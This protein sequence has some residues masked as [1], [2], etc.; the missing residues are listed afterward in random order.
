MDKY[1]PLRDAGTS[2][3]NF[4]LD[5]DAVIEHLRAWDARYGISLSDAGTDSVTVS[6]NEVPEDTGELAADIYAFCPDTVDQHFG[7]IGEMIDMCEETG[8]EVP[9]NVTEL[10]DGVTLEGDYGVELLER[11]LKKHKQVA[12]WWD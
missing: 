2:A 4:D 7:C 1:Q 3:G 8:E 12:L 11:S 6:F 9:P 5:T 10:V